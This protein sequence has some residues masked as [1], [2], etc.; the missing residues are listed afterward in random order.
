MEEMKKTDLKWR[1]KTCGTMFERDDALNMALMNFF[2]PVEV[3][4]EEVKKYK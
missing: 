4:I 1:C 2:V 3:E